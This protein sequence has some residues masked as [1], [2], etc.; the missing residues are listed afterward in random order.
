[1]RPFTKRPAVFLGPVV[2]LAIGWL[3]VM[4]FRDISADSAQ[5]RVLAAEDQKWEAELERARGRETVGHDIAAALCD[6]RITLE[7]AIESVMTLADDSPDWV[8]MLRSRYCYH[9]YVPSTASN[10]DVMTRYLRIQLESMKSVAESAGDRPRV[11][12]L[13]A[14]LAHLE[15]GGHASLLAAPSHE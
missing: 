13:S 9:G 1:M 10:H 6:G 14:H 8:V 15:D 5:L 4:E 12:S 2:L 3:A 11:V 7:E